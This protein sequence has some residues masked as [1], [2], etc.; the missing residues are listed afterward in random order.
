M[1]S[2]LRVAAKTYS[3]SPILL[4]QIVITRGSL[5][6]EVMTEVGRW[7]REGKTNHLTAKQDG[8]DTASQGSG[9]S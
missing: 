3:A 6:D 9:C 4:G 1:H 7:H 2:I 8:R 5:G